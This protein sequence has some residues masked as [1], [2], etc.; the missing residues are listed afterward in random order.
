MDGS[1]NVA[2]AGD[3]TVSGNDIT[4]GNTAKLTD[5]NGYI[6][7]EEPGGS[8]NF[9][10]FIKTQDADTDSYI[11]F[12]EGSTVKWNLG[13]DGSDSDTFKI[14]SNAGGALHTDTELSLDS[15]GHLA[16]AGDLTVSGNDIKGTGGTAITMDGSN[17]VTIAGDLTVTGGD[18]DLSGEVSEITL[19]D[20]TTTAINF[21]SPGATSVLGIGTSNNSESVK[22]NTSAHI[23]ATVAS[24]DIEGVN[25]ITGALTDGM[26]AGISL[27]PSYYS[28]SSLAVTR[29][30]YIS[31]EN[32]EAIGS[33]SLTDACVMR[34]D[35]NAGSH[36]AVD[37]GSAHPDIDTTD[38]WVKIN[39][40]GTIHYIPA[41]TDKS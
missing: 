27:D 15:S 23:N 25:T 6:I 10:L 31:Y 18:I 32:P 4:F 1:N 17:N 26:N 34:F 40:N 12:S 16:I 5:N 29:H 13:N 24:L 21:G 30:N 36:K 3:L 9:G 41:Y 33:A 22:I 39:I 7:I 11:T 8:N 38:A 28:S 35:A 2:V 37:S 19:I 20:N 14:S